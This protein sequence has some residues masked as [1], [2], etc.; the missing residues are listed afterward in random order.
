MFRRLMVLASTALITGVLAGCGTTDS[1]VQAH[2][3][4]G[5][6][7]QYG[8]ASQQQLL[9][10]R[11][12]QRAA[13]GVAA[14]GQGRPGRPGGA[15]VGQLP[16]RQ[17]AIGG[18]MLADG[19]GDRQQGPPALVHPAGAGRRP[20]QS[21]VRRVRQ[22]LHRPARRDAVLPADA[23]DP[24]ASASD[25]NAHHAKDSRAGPAAGRHASRAGAGVRRPQRHRRRHAA[26]SGRRRQ[27][28]RLHSGTGRLPTDAATLPGGRGAGILVGHRHRGGQPVGTER[29][30][31]GPGWASLPCRPDPAAH[32]RVDQRRGRPGADLQPRAVRRRVHRVRQRPRRA[33]VGAQHRERQAEMVCAAG[34]SGAD[35]AVGVA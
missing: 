12:G 20:V 27:S 16:C 30:G 9:A 4:D 35:A 28:D 31:A 17:R 15:R 2:A 11:G 13:A 10:R 18:R 21:A 33:P 34:L 14:F 3:A 24:V 25:R 26:G 1:W 7:A 8:D 6:P 23:V 19:V 29:R 5:W 32:P 22:S